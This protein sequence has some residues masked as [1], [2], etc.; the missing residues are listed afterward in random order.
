M[1]MSGRSFDADSGREF[2][3]VVRQAGTGG[4]CDNSRAVAEIL[5]KL[6]HDVLFFLGEIRAI[7]T[8]L[9]RVPTTRR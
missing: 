5:Q 7:I 2:W 3:N 4:G 9:R 1:M 6:I 8:F